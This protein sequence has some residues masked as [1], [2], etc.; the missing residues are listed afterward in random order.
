MEDLPLSLN[1]AISKI[2]SYENF[3]FASLE[4]GYVW[5]MLT[6]TRRAEYRR[7]VD[8]RSINL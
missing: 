5:G 4:F 1:P 3:V 8:S 2:S 7:S 6:F